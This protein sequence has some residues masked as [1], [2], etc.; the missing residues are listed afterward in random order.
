MLTE[1]VRH[2]GLEKVAVVTGSSKGIGKAIAIEFAKE[3]YKIV[4]NARDEKDL[5]EAVN[6]IKKTIV[7]DEQRITYLAGDIS[8]ENICASLVEHTIKTYGRIDVLVNNAGIGGAQKNV[9]ELTSDEWD[10]VIDVNLKG[11][12]L[13][14]R[15]AIKRMTHDGKGTGKTY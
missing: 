1:N 7:G 3:G 8:Q 10:Y 9:Y 2:D 15:E 11:A 14:T 12:F 6:D 4:L 5:S 13:C